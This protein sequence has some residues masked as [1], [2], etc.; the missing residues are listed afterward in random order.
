[1]SGQSA[2]P[3]KRSEVMALL[4]LRLSAACAAGGCVC[5][6]GQVGQRAGAA[7][8][9]RSAA[10]VAR[11]LQALRHLRQEGLADAA[12]FEQ[13]E[14]LVEALRRQRL[15]RGRSRVGDLARR[16]VRR[17]ALGQAAQVLDQHDAQGGRQCPELAER[18]LARLLVGL[19]ESGPAG[20]R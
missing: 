5:D 20:L 2:S 16:L 9:A 6:R 8:R 18:E 15:E 19:E 4:T 17:N 10:V 13:R 12:S 3:I 1:M 7:S 11:V 14:Q